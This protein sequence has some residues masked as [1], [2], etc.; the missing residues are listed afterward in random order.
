MYRDTQ[1]LRNGRG[2]ASSSKVPEWNGISNQDET[3]VIT[4]RYSHMGVRHEG[5]NTRPEKRNS[6]ERNLQ[7]NGYILQE[8]KLPKVP[9]ATRA[10]AGGTTLKFTSQVPEYKPFIARD[11][12]TPSMQ[13]DMFG[14]SSKNNDN[15]FVSLEF[16]SLGS[17]FLGRPKKALIY[18]GPRKDHDGLRFPNPQDLKN[19]DKAD[20]GE[21]TAKKVLFN[22]N[23]QRYGKFLKRCY[24][25]CKINS[26]FPINLL[27]VV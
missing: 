18:D 17:S 8:E 24:F 22:D 13:T 19:G 7:E 6:L 4:S 26:Y 1:P 3:K 10:N 20:S 9:A 11:T 21:V 14:P 16:G 5:I 15:G 23:Q 27:F 25:R 2:G 12:K